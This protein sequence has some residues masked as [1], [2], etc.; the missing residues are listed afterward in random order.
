M[1]YKSLRA[2]GVPV[3]ITPG[4]VKVDRE[5]M[6][7]LV[8]TTVEKGEP[9]GLPAEVMPGVELLKVYNAGGMK[10]YIFRVSEEGVTTL[11]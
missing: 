6:W 9:G 4:S 5:A 2:L 3:E 1:L 10:I 7:A 11:Q 8:A